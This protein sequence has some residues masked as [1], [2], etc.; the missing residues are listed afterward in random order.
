MHYDLSLFDCE[1]MNSESSG[2]P[3]YFDLCH[4]RWELRPWTRFLTTIRNEFEYGLAFSYDTTNAYTGKPVLQNFKWLYLVAAHRLSHLFPATGSATRQATLATEKTPFELD[5]VIEVTIGSKQ[6]WKCIQNWVQACSSEH[7]FCTHLSET[8]RCPRRL[9]YVGASADEDS[10][11]RLCEGR[12]IPNNVRYATLSHCWGKVVRHAKLTRA[13]LSDFKRQIPGEILSRSFKDA[14]LLTKRLNLH[15]LWVDSLCIIQD[16]PEDWERESRDMDAVYS[17]SFLNIAASAAEDGRG[18][19]FQFR[20]HQLQHPCKV[21]IAWTGDMGDYYITGRLY[22]S[23]HELRV[24]PLNKRGWVLQER[25][26]AP[27]TLHCAVDS[28]VWECNEGSYYEIFPETGTGVGTKALNKMTWLCEHKGQYPSRGEV[29]ELWGKIVM[30]YSK[31]ALSYERDK[32]VALDG[33]ISRL[34][35]LLNDVPVAGLWKEDIEYQLSWSHEVD[36]GTAV[37]HGPNV[38][39]SWSWASLSNLEIHLWLNDPSALSYR[40]HLLVL[41]IATELPPECSIP[42]DSHWSLR[43]RCWLR[44]WSSLNWSSLRFYILFCFDLISDV[45][46]WDDLWF[47]PVSSYVYNEDPHLDGLLLAREGNGNR[48]RRVGWFSIEKIYALRQFWTE[49]TSFGKHYTEFDGRLYDDI[50]VWKGFVS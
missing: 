42:S 28:F 21:R 27:R 19:C 25:I 15:W 30:M 45:G 34:Q 23:E 39:P 3:T 48:F 18:G 14:I 2:I 33:V 13:D 32:L 11:L 5:N 38:A 44:P 8:A 47:M 1:F 36:V 17:H 49:S 12:E 16:S 4:V 7:E 24:L 46:V 50:W 26:L 22:G 35:K 31:S 9:L 37:R 20:R 43:I 10:T 41:N 29:L 6:S 40:K